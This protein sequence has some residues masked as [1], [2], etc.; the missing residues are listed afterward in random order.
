MVRPRLG[1]FRLLPH[2]TID[3]L[4]R[5]HHGLMVFAA[6]LAGARV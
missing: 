2:M 6:E 4:V 5:V 1:Y 3:D